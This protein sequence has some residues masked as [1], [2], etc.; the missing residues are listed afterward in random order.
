MEKP[1]YTSTAFMFLALNA[2]GSIGAA[3]A[4]F[5]PPQ[6]AVI[7]STVSGVAYTLA[8]AWLK[9]PPAVVAGSAPVTMVRP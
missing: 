3:V 4:G 7:V 5:L 6:Y 8:N 1:G 2:I 9:R